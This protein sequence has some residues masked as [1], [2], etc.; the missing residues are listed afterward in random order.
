VNAP[1]AAVTA[2]ILTYQEAT[3]IRRCI[4]RVKPV[5]TRI[6]VVDSFSTD[7]TVEIA[8]ELGA[9][10]LQN[11]FVNHAH[12]FQWGIDNAGIDEGWILRIDADEYLEP[13]LIEEINERLATLP[14]RTTAIEMRRKVFFQGRWIR[15][16]G[17]YP[18]VLTRL[19]RVG[20]ARI[21][22]RWMDEH[23]VVEHGETLLLMRGDLVDDNLQDITWWTD[24][25]NGYTT[26]QMIEFISLE[27]P[28]LGLTR[29]QEGALN[30]AAKLK[31][32]LRKGLYARAP[33]YLRALLYFVQRY[34]LRLGFLDG[35]E[36]FV[37]HSLQGFWN[38]LL[39]DV[40]I[41]EARRFIAAQG[42]DAFRQHLASRHGIRH[43][44]AEGGIGEPALAPKSGKLP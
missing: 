41:G 42:I 3:H 37:F 1:S 34:F 33:L 20:A 19:W 26:K 30:R 35:R 8:R 16:G 21:E 4:E 31:R 18:I 25:H 14:E 24:K 17:Y 27:H 44:G 11:P 10:V 22:Q 38:F 32:F 29:P 9:E 43:A 36:G 6:V 40:K 2:V 23:I 12:Q 7:G 13:P 28:E 15:W 5:A 39:M